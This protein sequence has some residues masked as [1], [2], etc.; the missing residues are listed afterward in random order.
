MTTH[1]TTDSACSHA[2]S[3]HTSKP[4]ATSTYAV[5]GLWD[6]QLRS[7]R[8]KNTKLQQCKTKMIPES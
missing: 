3:Y 6:A 4:K 5:F 7:S 8:S 2:S 1:S